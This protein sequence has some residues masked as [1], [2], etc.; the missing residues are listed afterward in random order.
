MPSSKVNLYTEMAGDVT[1]LSGF[2]ADQVLTL[3][4]VSGGPPRLYSL[5]LYPCQQTENT[6]SNAILSTYSN[7]VPLLSPLKMRILC[8]EGGITHF[9]GWCHSGGELQLH[10][11][12]G[13]LVLHSSTTW[14][15]GDFCCTGTK[16]QT[17]IIKVN[18]ITMAQH[19]VTI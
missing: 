14:S 12:P 6:N 11:F 3:S 17:F 18:V 9:W 8:M 2:I 16:V 19:R 1:S 15:P 4:L 5:F 13:N 7:S 10:G